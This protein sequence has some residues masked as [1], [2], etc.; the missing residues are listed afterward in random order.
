MGEILIFSEKSINKEIQDYIIVSITQLIKTAK[1]INQYIIEDIE[2]ELKNLNNE[3]SI[4]NTSLKTILSER[5]RHI[6]AESTN[7]ERL[8]DIVSNSIINNSD[9]FNAAKIEVQQ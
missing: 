5:K 3:N 6:L 7:L 8:K 1:E 2:K 9:E 4:N